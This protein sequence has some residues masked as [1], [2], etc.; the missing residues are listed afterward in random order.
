MWSE[1]L[2]SLSVCLSELKEKQV[3]HKVTNSLTSSSCAS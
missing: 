1:I 2:L 3:T